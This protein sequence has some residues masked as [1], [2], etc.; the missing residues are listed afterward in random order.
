MVG[1]PWII[2]LLSIVG[3]QIFNSTADSAGFKFRAEPTPRGFGSIVRSP[4]AVAQ[5]RA[6]KIIDVAAKRI[7]V[8]DFIKPGEISSPEAILKALEQRASDVALEQIKDDPKWSFVGG[9]LTI[10]DASWRVGG[11]EVKLGEV[12]VYKVITRLFAVP[13]AACV[14][15]DQIDKRTECV[16]EVLDNLGFPARE[17]ERENLTGGKRSRGT[18]TKE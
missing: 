5:R 13:I 7:V 12:N 2:L 9:K 3:M 6:I 1:T 15:V 11:G 14:A 18:T 17:T 8:S 10:R 16:R 4:G